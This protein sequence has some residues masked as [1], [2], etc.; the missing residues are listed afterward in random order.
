MGCGRLDD[1]VDDQGTEALASPFVLRAALLLSAQ[2]ANHQCCCLLFPRL[3][4]AAGSLLVSKFLLVGLVVAL[5]AA[6][7]QCDIAIGGR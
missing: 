2:H 1:G 7:A 4:P 3:C 6:T 5:A